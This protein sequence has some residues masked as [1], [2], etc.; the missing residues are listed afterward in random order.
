MADTLFQQF[1]AAANFQEAF[2]KV[3]AKGS[4]G[5][6]D[7]V[8]LAAFARQAPFYLR[9]LRRE[10]AEGSYLPQP[11]AGVS[12]PKH[13]EHHGRRLLGL[14]TVA[15]KVV[16]MAL[17]QVVM[18]LAE[19]HFCDTSYGY[20][21]NKGP[22]KALR[23]VEHNLKSGKLTWVIHRDV[24]DFFDTLGH[25]RLLTLFG[26]LVHD[27]RRLLDLVALWCR[28]GM[29]GR[30]GHWRDLHAGVRQGQILSP[31]LANLYLHQLDCFVAG[32]GWGWVRYADDYLLQCAEKEVAL[33]AD[34]EVEAYL[35]G[36]RQPSPSCEMGWDAAIFCR[37]AS[38]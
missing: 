16:Q 32:Q 30:D 35:R 37:E 36:N 22:Y 20:R 28:S 2:A 34:R 27:D 13:D 10:V 17:Y 25:D 3:H 31:L 38:Q 24:D 1:I 9:R 26:E 14:P 21:P 23:R 6:V 7:G 5:G 19:R 33:R 11:V 15:D 18:P 8:S 29:V 12:V 4:V